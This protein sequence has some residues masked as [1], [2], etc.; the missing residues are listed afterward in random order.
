MHRRGGTYALSGADGGAAVS[1]G[2]KADLDH[3]KNMV[4]RSERFAGQR[5]RILYSE[6]KW[7]QY[8]NEWNELVRM[9]KLLHL[10]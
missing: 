6:G 7:N 3:D 4:E 5:E 1:R 9:K 10:W 8:K 2:K